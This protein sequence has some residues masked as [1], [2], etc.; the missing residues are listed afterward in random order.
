MPERLFDPAIHQSIEP[1]EG[2]RFDHTALVERIE[3]LK[4]A[5]TESMKEFMKAHPEFKSWN[6]AAL[7]AYSGLSEPTLKKL[8]TGQIADPRGSTF[9]ILFN[10]FGIRPRDVLKCIPPNLCNTDCANQAVMQLKDARQ[11]IEDLNQAH[12]A[13]QAELDRL[14]KMVLA[15]GE[16]LSATQAMAEN[17]SNAR[18]DLELVRKT[19]YQE[20][21]EHRRM[22]TAMIVLCAV[23]IIAL[24]AAVYLLWEATHPYS[25]LFGV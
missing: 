7:A 24:G 9:W 1:L 13:D 23:A 10:K 18:A 17:H 19:L 8:K 4:K 2:Y 22:R 11:R 3:T 5:P 25:G 16:A 14:R 20:R 12:A 15:K 6:C 21:V